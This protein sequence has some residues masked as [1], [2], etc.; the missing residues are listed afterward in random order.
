MQSYA[1]Q[2][3]AMLSCNKHFQFSFHKLSVKE[4]IMF[5]LLGDF[6]PL[7][8]LFNGQ[9]SGYSL[10]KSGQRKFGEGTYT[11]TKT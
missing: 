10:F 11:W 6:M 8:T 7:M 3:P 1:S 5:P 2:Y 9:V 4:K